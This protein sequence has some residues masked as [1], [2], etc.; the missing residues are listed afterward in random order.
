M[1]NISIPYFRDVII[2]AFNCSFCGAKSS[3]IKS[4]GKIS[5]KGMKIIFK[6]QNEH[7]LTRDLFKSE[8]AAISIPEFELELYHGCLGGVYTTVEGL[9]EKVINLKTKQF[10]FN[11]LIL[12][13]LKLFI[14]NE[15]FTH[16]FRNKNKVYF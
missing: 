1:C 2:M 7:D 4:G 5:E 15:Y 13:L 16:D 8:T 9:F 10:L 12:I 11:S 6:P 14:K 3:E